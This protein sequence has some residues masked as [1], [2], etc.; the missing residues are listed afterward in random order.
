MDWSY[1][2]TLVA[3][4]AVGLAVGHS[5]AEKSVD[6]IRED[7]EETLDEIVETNLRTLDIMSGINNSLLRLLQIMEPNKQAEKT[8]V[9]N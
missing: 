8:Q 7:H 2:I 9:I 6:E 1:W 3:V 4:F 5:G